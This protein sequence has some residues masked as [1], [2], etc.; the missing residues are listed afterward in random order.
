MKLA[1]KI[2]PQRSTQYARMTASVA[3]PELLASPLGAKLSA[4]E[5]ARLAGQDYLLATLDQDWQDGEVSEETRAILSRLGAISE[6]YEYFER[7]GEISGPWLR[8]VEP[9][10]TPFV[11][12][13]MTEARRYRGKTNEIFTHVLLNVALFAGAY[14]TR[15]HERLR[16]LDPLAGGGTTLF[17][18]LAN[19]YD[20][21]GIEL[22]RQDVETTA[23][24]VRQYLDGEHMRFKEIDERGRRAGR[25]YQFEIG[26]KG[27]TRYL[28]LANGDARDAQMQMREVVGGPRI[29][30][31]VADLPYGIQHFGEVAELLTRA[32]PLWEQML[33]PGG[34]IALAWN[35]TRVE[36]EEMV[37]LLEAHTSLQVRNEPPYTQFEHSVDRVIKRR[38]LLV[39][40]K[41]L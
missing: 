28:V 22:E 11:P 32:L 7:L 4:V 20:A 38:D 2:T 3:A 21:F 36:R 12:L 16:I 37:G 33:H 40:V 34:T 18:A 10:F 9:S 14:A 5:P 25:R 41:A 35:A 24:F 8:P 29:H 30:A 6:V 27:N 17:L 1:L 19:G 15:M 31:I 13:E 39:G 23:L 26:P